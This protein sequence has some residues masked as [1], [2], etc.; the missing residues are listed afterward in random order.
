MKKILWII[1]LC[2][3][4]TATKAQKTPDTRKILDKTAALFTGKGGVKAIFKA[5][6]FSNGNLQ[7]SISG[8]MCILG[9]KF[10]MST[11]EIITWYNGETQWSYIKASEEVNVNVPTPEEQQNLNPY[12]FIG[13]YKKG[14]GYQLKET[15]LRGKACYE[16][17]LTAQNKQ[18]HPYVIIMDIDKNIHVPMCIR[19]Q[20][21]KEDKWTRISIHQFHTG[22]SFSANDF[23]F[24]PKD[25]PQAE[26]IDLR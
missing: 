9:N 12:T 25:Y 19:I 26:I 13:L 6:N 2:M 5:D 11:P 14:Y 8:T 7:G 23:E 21:Q 24:N 16:I 15:N 22:Q 4:V 18:K 10:Q 3:T 1:V 17:T 20:P